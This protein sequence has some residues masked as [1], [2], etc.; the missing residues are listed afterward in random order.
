MRFI[1]RKKSLQNKEG[2]L[3]ERNYESSNEDSSREGE[4]TRTPTLSW[5]MVCAEMLWPAACSPYEHAT[6]VHAHMHARTPTRAAHRAMLLIID[7][8]DLPRVVCGLVSPCSRQSRH[9]NY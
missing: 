1:K 8:I 2:E 6:S 7:V 4:V 3:A 9:I 5:M